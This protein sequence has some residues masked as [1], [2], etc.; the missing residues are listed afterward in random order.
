[1]YHTVIT[2]CTAQWSIYV[3]NFGQYMYRTVV[4]LCTAQWSLY[5]PQN[6]TFSNST[7]CPRS[8]FMCFVRN[9]EKSAIISLFNINWLS[10]II[11]AVCLYCAVRTAR[12]Y[13][14]QKIN[15]YERL[16]E[17]AQFYSKHKCLCDFKSPRIGFRPATKF[18]TLQFIS[19][20]QEL[21]I[22]YQ[23]FYQPINFQGQFSYT[24]LVQCSFPTN[25]IQEDQKLELSEFTKKIEK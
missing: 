1:M 12:L 3:P 18:C 6:L 19:I 5:V 17:T 24:E 14:V 4:I 2:I 20:V 11:E 22:V 25:K 15:S 16:L 8:V 7:F 23:S 21:R 9:W 13:I 10:L